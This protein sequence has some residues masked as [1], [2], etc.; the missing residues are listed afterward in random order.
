MAVVTMAI[1]A[2]AL[3]LPCY[4]A[5]SAAGA[6]TNKVAMADAFSRH[7]VARARLVEVDDAAAAPAATAPLG[8]PVVVKPADSQGQRGTTKVID[9]AQI[10]EAVS[11]AL[12]SSRAG[13][14]VV[15]EFVA[16]PEITVSVWIDDAG[17]RILAVTDRVTYNPPPAIGIAVQHVFP[18]IHAAG[19]LDE[20][21]AQVDAIAMA[22][23]MTRGPLYIQ[24][25][26]TPERVVVVEAGARVGGGHEA[27]LIPLVTGVDV[28]DRLIDL[29]LTG[30]CDPAGYDFADTADQRHALVNFLVARPGVV[31]RLEGIDGMVDRGEIAEGSFYIAP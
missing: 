11:L 20:V 27:S 3:D 13:V 8:F 31:E 7:G 30:D 23:G 10:T 22:Y 28:T 16:A 15:E 21:K 9:P 1:V 12:D 26:V 5:A 17:P 4:L 19:R 25:L 14:A 6:A 18:S 29:A 24:M 2:D